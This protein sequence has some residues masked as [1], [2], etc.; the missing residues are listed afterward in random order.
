MYLTKLRSI[1]KH[2]VIPINEC[3][4]YFFSECCVWLSQRGGVV[5]F[6]EPLLVFFTMSRLSCKAEF[7]SWCPNPPKK[8]LLLITNQIHLSSEKMKP[9][10][11]VTDLDWWLLCCF[12]FRWVLF[13]GSWSFSTEKIVEQEKC[14]LPSESTS[15]LRSRH[16]YPPRRFHS[17]V[18][19]MLRC[20]WK[21]RVPCSSM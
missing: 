10:V 20:G 11:Q 19:T 6:D 21:N 4:Q 2:N 12:I 13:C 1:M 7:N 18:K 17:S 9:Q 15:C 5:V 14:G 3:F 16:I 8:A